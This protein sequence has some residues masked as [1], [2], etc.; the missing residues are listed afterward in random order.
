MITSEQ[1]R[2]IM[3]RIDAI[4]WDDAEGSWAFIDR[5]CR[6]M[7]LDSAST[8][9]DD[10]R[11]ITGKVRELCEADELDAMSDEELSS[12]GLLR[13]PVGA[14]GV[15]VVPGQDVYSA[16]G[17]CWRVIGVVVGT[18]PVIAVPHG[19]HTDRREYSRLEPSWLR[20]RRD[21]PSTLADEIGRWVDSE[22]EAAEAFRLYTGRIEAAVRAE[23][24]VRCRDCAHM[25]ENPLLDL[26][27]CL[28]LGALIPDAGGF[29]AWGERREDAQV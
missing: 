16:D 11:S 20:H 3:A 2:E 7:G 22:Q 13:L 8:Y 19:A 17:R 6:A 21:T 23:E 27:L 25:H 5:L 29:C 4:S 12:H 9:K 24:P 10:M 26:P 15:T 18:R 1:R 28:F 14:D